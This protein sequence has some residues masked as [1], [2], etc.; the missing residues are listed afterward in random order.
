MF[1]C[2]CIH[3]LS[4]WIQLP[5]YPSKSVCLCSY[6]CVF[7]ALSLIL[8]PGTNV[9]RN[10]SLSIFIFLSASLQLLVDLFI[11]ISMS[12]HPPCVNILSI[13]LWIQCSY[14]QL[15]LYHIISGFRT[16]ESLG[17]YK[18]FYLY[19]SMY[20]HE[21]VFIDIFTAISN[22]SAVVPALQLP[23]CLRI[24]P[25]LCVTQICCVFVPNSS[26][27][28]PLIDIPLPSLS[29]MS[30]AGN[31][32]LLG[33]RIHLWCFW[34]PP[35]RCRMYTIHLSLISWSQ[36]DHLR[37]YQCRRAGMIFLVCHHPL[38]VC[39]PSSISTHLWMD[40][41]VFYNAWLFQGAP[42]ETLQFRCDGE[43]SFSL[44]SSPG[45]LWFGDLLVGAFFAF[46]EIC[47]VCLQQYC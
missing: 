17:L 11:Y 24:Y 36:C 5:L 9:D 3:L 47:R 38:H 7:V 46:E 27:T 31:L 26:V 10:T 18:H 6:E 25:L 23:F 41:L 39:R 44:D 12:F 40:I 29:L 8:S 20:L 19:Q 33:K 4:P 43:G 32:F 15:Y 45:V 22:S 35:E 1:L 30:P 42:Q 14:I 13:T 16:S 37:D 34:I 28:L 21:H 2:V